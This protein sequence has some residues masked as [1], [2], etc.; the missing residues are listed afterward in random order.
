MLPAV[1]MRGH[2]RR[3]PPAPTPTTPRFA[4]RQQE[5]GRSSSGTRHTHLCHDGSEPREHPSRVAAR[6]AASSNSGGGVALVAK[7]IPQHLIAMP[8]PHA[9]RPQTR[10][11]RAPPV[12]TSQPSA[13]STSR[14]SWPSPNTTTSVTCKHDVRPRPGPTAAMTVLTA[15]RQPAAAHTAC[16]HGTATMNG[17]IARHA[18]RTACCIRAARSTRL[19]WTPALP[20]RRLRNVSQVLLPLQ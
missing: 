11:P 15:T 12:Q 3:C 17:L 7:S 2:R 10:M 18:S 8:H 20:P 19:M 4:A 16:L 5:N 1:Q 13:C 6:V 14:F 9:S